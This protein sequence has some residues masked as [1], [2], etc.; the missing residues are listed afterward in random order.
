[1]AWA[2]TPVTNSPEKPIRKCARQ[3]LPWDEI[4]VTN[5]EAGN[6]SKIDR[7]P[8]RPALNKTG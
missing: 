6:E 1:M 3:R 5:C 4:T 8:D 7:I 2:A